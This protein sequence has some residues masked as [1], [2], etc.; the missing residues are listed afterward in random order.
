MR[1]AE[2]K[3]KATIV[4]I[5]SKSFEKN[6]S[7]NFIIRGDKKRDKRIK[8]LMSYSFNYCKRNGEVF[9]SEDGQGCALIVF[10][11]KKKFSFSGVLQDLLLVFKSIG[12]KNLKKTMKRESLIRKNQP[13]SQLYYLWYIGVAPLAQG[14]G[15]GSRLLRELIQKGSMM[16]R[17]ICLETSTLKNLP[18]YE[19]NGFV[20][21]KTLDMGYP[22][23]F[24]K[25]QT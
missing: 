25:Y 18:W 1:E 19:K 24:M 21:Y 17:T 3:D 6:Q 2:T 5:L 16:K 12:F 23:Y 11:D 22:L 9:V 14:K 20:T 15:I 13:D 7:V 10:P 8:S 4:E